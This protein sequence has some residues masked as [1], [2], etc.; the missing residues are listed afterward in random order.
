MTKEFRKT[1]ADKEKL[2]NLT[3]MFQDNQGIYGLK[4]DV[5]KLIDF[6]PKCGPK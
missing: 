4:S 5:Y 6:V 3:G 2:E 1:N